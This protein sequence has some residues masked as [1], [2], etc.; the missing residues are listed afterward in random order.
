MRHI[1]LIIA[2]LALAIA[3]PAIA[4]KGGTEVAGNS[5][6]HDGGGSGGDGG[7]TGSLDANPTRPRG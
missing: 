5:G 2:V 1:T 7:Y 3:A 6:S 4:G